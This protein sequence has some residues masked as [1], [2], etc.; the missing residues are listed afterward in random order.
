MGRVWVFFRCHTAPGFQLWFY[1]YLC[2]LAVRW[3]LLL[4]LPWRTWVCPCE[5]RVWRWCSCLGHRASGS[6][7]Y[8]GEL[9]ARAAENTVPWTGMASSISPYAPVFL[10]REPSS[11][12][13][14]PGRPHS[15][16]WQRVGHYRSAPVC[17]D[18]RFLCLWQLCPNDS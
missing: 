5:G 17:I 9:A 16:G 12:T 18:A 10:P 6:T 8:S 15:T 13:E 1:F 3:G 11:L 7:R 14:K 4:R 2:M